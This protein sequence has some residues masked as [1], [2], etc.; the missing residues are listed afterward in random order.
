M[1]GPV[2]TVLE[3]LPRPTYR[4]LAI[5][6]LEPRRRQAALDFRRLHKRPPNTTGAVILDHDEN[7][8][9][10]DSEHFRV[11]PVGGQIESVAESV[12]RPDIGPKLLVEMPQCR[13]ADFRRERNRAADRGGRDGAVVVLRRRRA[14]G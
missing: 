13:K 5:R 7:R 8:A 14:T 9:L 12:R 2:M 1:S 6:S 10:I 3:A 11:P 4:F